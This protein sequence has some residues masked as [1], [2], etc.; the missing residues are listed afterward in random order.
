MREYIPIKFVFLIVLNNCEPMI[1]QL[2][3]VFVTNFMVLEDYDRCTQ[4]PLD[5]TFKW[6]YAVLIIKQWNELSLEMLKA[7]RFLIH[8]RLW[9]SMRVFSWNAIIWRSLI[10]L[11]IYTRSTRR[12]GI[13]YPYGLPPILTK[14]IP[15]W[16]EITVDICVS[17]KLSFGA[18]QGY[19]F[20]S[21]LDKSLI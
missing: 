17:W 16:N 13:L 2:P 10:L 12:S 8:Y 14:P 1:F 4:W 15:S 11:W 20:T 21:N 9:N 18:I 6:K 5:Y 19:L 7:F 3:L